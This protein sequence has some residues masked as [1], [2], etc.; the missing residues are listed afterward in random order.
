MESEYIDKKLKNDTTKTKWLSE[1]YNWF[2][3][4]KELMPHY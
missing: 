1:E 4:K 3:L 2:G